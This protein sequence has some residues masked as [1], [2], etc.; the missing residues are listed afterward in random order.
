[1][2]SADGLGTRGIKFLFVGG[3]NTAATYLL[4]VILVL[5]GVHHNLALTLEYLMGIVC[6]YVMNRRWTFAQ[7]GTAP[8]SF[9]RY[10]ATYVVVYLINLMLLN[11]LIGAGILGPML[12]QFAALGVA[13][14]I[15]F[16]L[17]NFWVF[18]RVSTLHRL[19]S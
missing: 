8:R 14:G 18:R 19:G 7:H 4:Y 9:P 16:L 15:A 3:F 1:M 12:G 5:V 11:L 2:S 13:T 6:G 10:C 17:Q